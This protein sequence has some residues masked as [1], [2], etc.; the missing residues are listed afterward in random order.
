MQ[1]AGCGHRRR[2]A[3][4]AEARAAKRT[5]LRLAGTRRAAS[6]A[7]WKR[8]RDRPGCRSYR[9]PGASLPGGPAARPKSAGP[10][11]PAIRNTTTSR[12]E[13][14]TKTG[15]KPPSA[16]PAAAGQLP[17]GFVG[18]DTCTACHDREGQSLQR[19][20]HGR[21]QNVR[22]PAGAA[23]QACETCHGPGREHAESGD[24][25]KIRRFTAIAAREASE[26][27]LTC[28]TRGDHAF[29]KGSAHDSRTLSCVT[30]HS[31]HSPKS[32]TAQLKAV[33]YQR[34]LEA[35]KAATEE[36]ERAA[37]EQAEA[38]AKLREEQLKAA[39]EAALRREREQRFSY[40]P[41]CSAKVAYGDRNCPSCQRRI[42]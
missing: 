23:N 42:Y 33:A 29:W 41:K 3:S 37:K 4:S 25:T 5:K 30:C 34:Q 21:A 1:P 12:P 14:A 2:Q 40:C 35:H 13:T 11:R 9:S 27:C 32:A 38:A 10:A 17:A 8:A 16:P 20:L 19:S 18:D 22:T 26:V 36:R 31:V 15:P 7:A 39:Q 24:A 6:A 28:H